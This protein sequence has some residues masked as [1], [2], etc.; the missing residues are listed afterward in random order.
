[1]RNIFIRELTTRA[2]I[3]SSIVLITGDLGFGVLDDFR[4]VCPSQ[5][6]NAGI[7]EQSMISLAAGFSTLGFR[8]FVYSIANFPT[9]RALE[10]IRND[11]SYMNHPVT[12]VSVGA[13]LSYGALGYTHHAV[14]DLSILHALPNIQIFSPNT[15][16][17]V[18]WALNEILALRSPAYLRLGVLEPEQEGVLSMKG[19]DSCFDIDIDAYDGVICWTGS[20]AKLAFGARGELRLQGKNPLLISMP[21]LTSA[22]FSKLFDVIQDKPLLTLEEHVLRGGFGSMALESASDLGR[23]LP[24]KR[25][26][27]SPETNNQIGSRDYLLNF[28]EVSKIRIIKTYNSFFN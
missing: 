20:M 22:C 3:D 21:L 17:E 10:Q 8:P 27:I 13:G 11:V 15:E 2:R 9:F 4:V 26:G 19:S 7:A 5:F 24:I 18:V 28:S 16:S 25:I 12:I 1:M 6:V 14:E 23:N